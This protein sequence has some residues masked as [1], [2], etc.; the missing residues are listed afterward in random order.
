[1]SKKAGWLIFSLII[2]FSLMLSAC[3]AAAPY[4]SLKR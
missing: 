4:R 2:V 1:M 3:Q